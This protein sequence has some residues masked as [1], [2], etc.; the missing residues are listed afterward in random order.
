MVHKKGAKKFSNRLDLK[1]VIANIYQ[2]APLPS[3][4]QPTWK[5]GIVP[6][7]N[8]ERVVYQNKLKAISAEQNS[9]S[10]GFDIHEE[11]DWLEG[12]RKEISD[13]Q[14]RKLFSNIRIMDATFDLHGLSELEAKKEFIRCIKL[15]FESN[16]YAILFIHGK[17]TH[18]K[19]GRSILKEGI[20]NWL[21]LD[22]VRHCVL[23]WKTA[24]E[25]FGG[26]GAVIVLLAKGRDRIMR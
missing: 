20:K 21:E 26:S 9:K 12:Y 25:W 1:K 4:E 8:R 15:C 7:S 19:D 11:P 14:R 18:S 13:R 2:E 22:A 3:V 24:P 16:Y 17:G 23:A 6:L 10:I 5:N